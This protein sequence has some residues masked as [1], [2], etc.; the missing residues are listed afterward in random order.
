MCRGS[1]DLSALAGCG[2]V[3]RL[4]FVL[5]L[6]LAGC[7]AGATATVPANN[8]AALPLATSAAATNEPEPEVPEVVRE[9]PSRGSMVV[10][11][12]LHVV[13][14]EGDPNSELSSQRTID[15]VTEVAERMRDIWA[16]ADVVFDPVNVNVLEIPTSVLFGISRGDTSPFFDQV[17]RTFTP[18][19]AQALNGFYVRSA[20][21]VNGFAP[22]GSNVFF[23]V[24]EPSV[25]D[26]RVSS[27]EIGHI[28]GLHHDLQDDTQLMFSGTNGTGLSAIEQTVS[29]YGI[30]RIF[31]QDVA[32]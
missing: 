4:I 20:F 1:E 30:Q 24:D 15:E 31:P 7:T 21:G 26:E 23:V 12:T 17:N 29:R 14:E 32:P 11:L 22:I 16:Q 13:I 8:T 18:E 28:F 19:D 3:R 6:V 5:A 27:H 2:H 10:P 9:T 25:H